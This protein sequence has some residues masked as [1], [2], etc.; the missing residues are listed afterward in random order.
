MEQDSTSK[1]GGEPNPIDTTGLCLLSLDGGGVRG[2]SSL[3]ILKSIMDRLNHVR[4][5]HKLPPVKPC[6]VFDL[7]GGTSTGGLIAIMLGRL[8]M[9]VDKCIDAYSELAA[10]VFG[11]KLSLIPVNF[12]GDIRPQFDSAK[13]E[14]AIQKMIE[15]SGA[16]KQDLFNDGTERGCRTFVCT[17]D[18]HTKDIVRLRSY[19]LSHEPNIRAT[20]CQ[21]A[22]ATSAATT[23]FEPV[24]IGDRSFADGGL[25][26]NNP[27][28][29]VEGEASNIWC[30]ETGDLKRLVKCFISIGTGNPGRQA[31]EDSI[32]KFLRQTLVQIATETENTERRF[33]ARWARHFDEKR[34]F[35]FNV[36]QGL[37]KIG[38]EEYK[39]KG[40]IEAATEDYLTHLTQKFRVRDC[41]QNMRLKENQTGT[42]FST[43]IQEYTVRWQSVHRFA[44]PLDLTAVP[45]TGNFVGRQDELDKL[46]QYLQPKSSR[47]RKVAILHGLGGIGKT[48]LAL[49][50]AR[51]H[52]DDFTAIFW[53]SGKDR[54]TL[55]RS[56]SSILPRLPGQSQN[57]EVVNNEE[58]EQRARELLYWL[59]LD[60]NSRW[61]IIFDSVDQYS[62]IRSSVDGAYD[63]R[64]FFPTANHG[65]ILITTRLQRLIELGRPLP[66]K[67][68]GSNDAIQLLLQSSGLS[69]RNS[70]T[71]IESNPDI[72][73]LAVRLDGLPLAIVIA[74]AFMRETG[75][76]ITD[77]LQYYQESWFELHSK[78]SPGRQYQKGNMF[79]T[80]MISYNEVKM[81][82]PDAAKLLLLLACFD[83][84]DIWY[85]LVHCCSRSPNVPAWLKRPVSDKLAFKSSLKTLIEFSL[86]ESKQ[87][88]GSYSMHPV[89]QEWC[90][91]VAGAEGRLDLTQLNELALIC[92]GYSVP[93][94]SDKNYSELQRRLIP[95][96]NHVRHGD[97]R[98]GNIAVMEACHNIGNLNKDQGK[99][100]EAEEMYQQALSGREMALG[101][102]HAS[103]LDTV[104]NIGSLYVDQR[105]LK[106]A[107]GMFQRALTGYE[108]TLGP[109]HLSTL[110]TVNNL[111]RLYRIRGSLK[112][113]EMMS[114]R[115]LAGYEKT[116]GPGHPSTL[117]TVNNLGRLYVDQGKLK[118]A[119]MMYQRALSGYEKALSPDHTST[120][121]TVNNIGSLYVGQGKLK[122]AEEMFQRALTGYERA[123]GPD[124]TSTLDTV[125][126]IGSLYVGQGKLKEAEEMYQQALAG[127][128]IAL[129]PDHTSTLDTVNNIGSLYVGQG[130]LKEAEEM[131]RRALTG[132][133]KALG[134]DNTPTL[135]TINNIGNLYSDRG[136]LKEAEEMF[137]QALAGYEKA[138][139]P[140]HTST[141][142]TVNNLGRL[143][144]DQGKLKEA[145]MMYQRAL[146][147]YE[148]TLGPDHL[149][150]LDTVNNLGRLYRI[151]GN[152]KKAEMMSQRALAGYEKTLGPGHPST[153][154]TVNN[155]G[156]LYVDQGKL[157]KAEDMFQRALSGYEKTLGPD[158]LSTL[159]TVN[160]LG[161]IYRIQDKLKEAEMMYQRALAG[162]EVALGPDH[163]S[164]LVTVNN[165]GNLY[166]D[167]GKLK[168][169]EEMYQQ[170]L[171]GYEK[172]LGPDH[173]STL[174][175]VNNLGNLY[176][177]QGKLKEAENMYQRALAGYEKALGPDHTCTLDTV[178]NIGSLYQI[179]GKL[180]EAEEMYQR[181]LAGYEKALGPDHTSILVTVNNI[182]NL[183]SDQGKLKEAEEM[184]QR[185][186]A[187]YEKA[188]GPDHTSTLDTVNNIGSLYVG[189]G[190]LKEAEEMYQ[191]ALAGYE[192]ALGPDHTSTLN[193]VNDLGSLYQ[194]QGKLKEAEE[195]YQRAPAYDHQASI[196]ES[197]DQAET[198]DEDSGKT[199]VVSDVPCLV[200]SSTSSLETISSSK[201]RK[202]ARQSAPEH[203]AKIL[204]DDPFL[205][206]L[207]AQAMQKIGRNRFLK[208]HDRL[209]RRYLA[210]LRLETQDRVVLELVRI[211][212]HRSRRQQVTVH[213]LEHFQPTSNLVKENALRKFL[214]QTEDREYR[215]RSFLQMQSEDFID[216]T[217]DIAG[218]ANTMENDNKS[219]E[220]IGRNEES[221]YYV[222]DASNDDEEEEDVDESDEEERAADTID[223]AKLQHLHSVVAF[224][225]KGRPFEAFK[226]SFANFLNPPLTIEEAVAS[227][228]IEIIR[229]LLKKRSH[230]LAAGE[231]SWLHELDE[232]GYTPNDIADVLLEQAR[233]GPW[234][235]DELPQDH[236]GHLARRDSHIPGCI[237]Q[238]SCEIPQQHYLDTGPASL[239]EKLDSHNELILKVQG[240]CGLGGVIPVSENQDEWDGTINVALSGATV[241]YLKGSEQ[242]IT[243]GDATSKL[244]IRAKNALKRT[245]QA[246]GC[247]QEQGLC[248]DSF[249]ALICDRTSESDTRLQLVRINIE[250]ALRLYQDLSRLTREYDSEYELQQS[251]MREKEH[252]LDSTARILGPLQACLDDVS[253][254]ED[255]T[256]CILQHCILSVQFFSLG[257]VSYVQGHCS[258]LRPFFIDHGLEHV[259][260]C[261]IG[262]G[263]TPNILCSLVKLSC[264]DSMLESPVF[265]FSK[266]TDNV[267]ECEISPPQRAM[268]DDEVERFNVLTTSVDLIDTW[269]PAKVVSERTQPSPRA[270]AILI[271]GGL[272]SME[273]VRSD[274]PL[275]HWS[276]AAA[277]H[278]DC[279]SFS[280]TQNVEVGGPLVVNDTCVT[281]FDRTPLNP[282]LPSEV[283]GPFESYW[284]LASRQVG[285]SVGVGEKGAF[286]LQANQGWL[287]EPECTIK[288][289][290]QAEPEKY[291]IHWLLDS[292]WAIQISA[293]TGAAQRVKLREL[294][295]DLLPIY[296]DS[297]WNPPDW[298]DLWEEHQIFKALR[299]A[300]DLQQWGR[301]LN[302]DSRGRVEA[303]VRELLLALVPTGGKLLGQ[304]ACGFE[305]NRY[306]RLHD[307]SVS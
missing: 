54:G 268:I 293:C 149:S 4:R 280:L 153:L 301:N 71:E 133:E 27:V 97:W 220:E 96:A 173:T 265:A 121:D 227:G 257:F 144:V 8:E 200:F 58:M 240:F 223:E 218:M 123:L 90:L 213:V 83:N 305:Q 193:T 204:S 273:Q 25:G 203:L 30:P 137:Q 39:K 9:D 272:I 81:R 259:T 230:L 91:N 35:R 307:S 219:T 59:A 226:S 161:R 191:R 10:A 249:T 157:K 152:L 168:E 42:D 199:S 255:I 192:K 229:E 178:N 67:R 216:T 246:L 228:N 169:A 41:I 201:S 237:H 177:A 116:L 52:K 287:K 50:F 1:H 170:A 61:L 196:S 105:K 12:K 77:Y 40:A 266:R 57:T 147:G 154:N 33:I 19:S 23:F 251:L 13:L 289:H 270:A 92:V 260:L 210:D 292:P 209:L 94:T 100:K 2:L 195:M 183:Y 165:L 185:A 14:S 20:I 64:E 174:V 130:K 63:I 160:N 69:S 164:T 74:G 75:T 303:L 239:R 285:A 120:L 222:E 127:Y 231:Y 72:L 202:D 70:M 15:D 109:D 281:Q 24:N 107:E 93:S 119:E 197:L 271:R 102:D 187:G 87:H 207:Y 145:E 290:F 295:A 103:T 79:Q 134:P 190:K 88:E 45:V 68:L 141:L 214:D 278:G 114:Q 294:V 65:S 274:T 26:A 156:R 163:T 99:L 302:S 29:E 125:N 112:K 166:S 150:T 21:A 244:F 300:D 31:F 76:S 34:Y 84:R 36:E 263:Y 306:V 108:K 233:E 37:Q 117:N 140:D 155:L 48:Q 18:R 221:G 264:L 146:S 269:G 56:L 182:G 198:S 159:D 206:R 241:S 175:T 158:H 225:T 284:R 279:K 291:Q 44:V 53:L 211:L 261:G 113:A 98:D 60:G 131:F 212:Q 118:E 16:S 126:N 217:A 232:I 62:P 248:C 124:H 47:S 3:Y 288:G 245:L 55:L 181:A 5:E 297:R 252:L 7:I 95:H 189:Q 78:S 299:S 275:L 258:V 250:P 17:A 111:G 282:S 135:A 243:G 115:A 6:E 283:L 148:K 186:L 129:G 66:V 208:T 298:K 51:D 188:L 122:E 304:D 254:F 89:V 85:E 277:I 215:L 110:D 236:T 49:R 224:F 132:Y 86:I 143:Y 194:I 276:R 167:Q 80:W 180:K 247:V 106:K 104:N 172:A 262:A 136:R 28:D 139:G 22:L 46:W 162:R 286:N 242:T 142:N 176:S 128:E 43:V 238:L 184:Y 171:A 267:R 101:P 82:D 179:Q 296:T 235:L 151:R 11:E 38:L 73:A 256:S 32:F 253:H 138:L 234:I 205:H